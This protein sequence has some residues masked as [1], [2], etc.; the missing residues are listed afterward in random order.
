[1]GWAVAAGAGVKP[2]MI[3]GLQFV[4]GQHP[5]I[6]QAIQAAIG[7]TASHDALPGRN[8]SDHG[9][10]QQLLLD[11]R[12]QLGKPRVV[13]EYLNVACIRRHEAIHC[14]RRRGYI[15]APFTQLE[16]ER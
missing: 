4:H 11:V 9:H 13:V 2:P 12:G 15:A 1:M 16:V 14:E 3:P 6:E 7:L 10:R 5:T 8:L